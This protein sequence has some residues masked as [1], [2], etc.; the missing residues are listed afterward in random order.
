MKIK[1][2][3]EN[4]KKQQQID[5]A[6]K[7]YLIGAGLALGGMFGSQDAQAGVEGYNT[8]TIEFAIAFAKEGIKNSKDIDKSIMYS[9][10]L[11]DL[12][13]VNKTPEKEKIQ[14][15]NQEAQDLIKTI[16]NFLKKATPEDLK[17]VN[18]LIDKNKEIETIVK[19]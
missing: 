16:D 17:W 3:K 10:A 4:K 15:L 2:I 6:F 9:K 19:Q 14:N 13:I 5:E 11:E 1:I 7:D 8:Q 18:S 12:Q